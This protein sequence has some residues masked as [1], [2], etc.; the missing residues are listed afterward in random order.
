MS[1]D[2][3]PACYSDVQQRRGAGGGELRKQ[4]I[5]GK[6]NRQ[7]K[8]VFKSLY[9]WYSYWPERWTELRWQ[10]GAAFVDRAGR[11][12]VAFARAPALPQES[13]SETRREWN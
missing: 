13:Q 2:I 12:E 11:A 6:P 9:Q 4:L 3:R 1:R 7:I 10:P 8:Q 5:A